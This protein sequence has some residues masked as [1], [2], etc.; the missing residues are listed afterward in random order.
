MSTIYA[1]ATPAGRGGVSVVRLSGPEARLIAEAIAGELPV[2]RRAELRS[3]RDGELID[4]AL[5][6]RFDEGASFTGETVVEFQ[7][8][9]APVVVRRLQE[10]LRA[11][12]ARLAEAGE[13]TRRGLL[14]GALALSEV[15]ALSDLL[16]AESEAQRQQAMRVVS[17]ELARWAEGLRERLVRAGALIEVSLDFADEEVPEEVP[18]EVF[19][20]LDSVRVDIAAAVAGLPAAERLRAGFEVAIV[21]PPNAGKSS[22]LNRIARREMALVSDVAGTTRDVLELHTELGGLAVT[23]LDT[24]GLREAEDFVEGLGLDRARDRARQAD[25]RLHLSEDERAVEELYQDGDLVLRSKADLGGRGISAVTGAGVSEMLE[26]LRRRLAERVAGAGLVTR[27]RQADA[28]EDALAVLAV[29]RGQ[30][31]ELLAEAVRQASHRLSEV[32][33]KI[34][35]DDYLDEIFSRFCIGK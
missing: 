20:L 21:G 23:F 27:K 29:R 14:N 8:H 5:V 25:L 16:A 19:E 32:V 2:A 7:L 12:G 31:A 3:L 4:R 17:G 18:E 22:L 33:G 11:R 35:P 30:P 13:F 34:A 10:A 15:E 9:G 24:A 28:L 26:E 6:I 1:E